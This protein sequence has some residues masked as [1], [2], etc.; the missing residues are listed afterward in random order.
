MTYTNDLNHSIRTWYLIA[1]ENRQYRFNYNSRNVDD[2]Q[3]RVDREGNIVIVLIQLNEQLRGQGAFG[4]FI[5]AL[6]QIAPVNVEIPQ[7][8]LAAWCERHNIPVV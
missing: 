8:R 1:R 5:E 7:P 3:M 4:R 6:Q 2:L